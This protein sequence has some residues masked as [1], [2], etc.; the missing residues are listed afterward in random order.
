MISKTINEFLTHKLPEL[1][2]AVIG[3]IMVDR[4]VFGDVGRISPEAPVPVNRVTDVKEVLG[5]AANVAN[6]LA[7]LDCHVFLGG[8]AGT[9]SHGD[10]LT[11]L[12]ET[13]HIN[14]EGVLRLSSR[15]T[16]TKMRILGG[17]QQMM[18]LD[19]EEPEA[20]SEQEAKQL[21]AWLSELCEIG[22]DGIVISDYGK[23][24]CTPAVLKAVIT[25]ANAKGIK[26]IVDPKGNDWSKYSGAT[27][28]TPNVKE[29]S[30]YIGRSLDNTDEAIVTAAKETLAQVSF[31]YV[32]AT[33]SAKGI[34][35]VSQEGKVWHNPATQ[36]DVFDVSGAGDT[37]VAMIITAMAAGLTVRGT[38]HVA[39]AAAGVVVSKVGTYPIHRQELLDLWEAIRHRQADPITAYSREEMA[40]KIRQWQNEGHTVVFTN[41]CFD[42][43]HS[44][45]LS[46]LRDAARLGDHLVVGLNSDASVKR[47][48]GSARPINSESSRAELMGALGFVDGV[49]VFEE[50]TP[51]ELLHELRPNILV[52]GG[53]YS[54]DQV[55][56]CE[57][58]DKVII[59]PFKEGYST[60]GIIEKIKALVQEGLL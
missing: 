3:D 27:F 2:I 44:G 55:I 60:T 59:L 43:L 38:L 58:V 19:F 21:L 39:N 45:H 37:V 26:T 5:G 6:N 1:R 18:R 8:V 52:K 12:L 33:R 11:H 40:A 14:H 48:K 41:G 32:V 29:L 23:G 17:R 34:T 46:Y 50:D 54:V 42:I 35:I 47:L 25:M 57:F 20:V 53:D 56:G 7:N 4:Y 31:D 30:E 28:I 49:V 15:Q 16:T 10:L 51:A 36:Q 9:D 24:V 13:E 22:L